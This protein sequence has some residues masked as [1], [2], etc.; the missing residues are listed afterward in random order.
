[1]SAREKEA[2]ET[3][4]EVA[5]ESPTGLDR[6]VVV[7]VDRDAREVIV[8]VGDSKARLD[9]VAMAELCKQTNRAFVEVA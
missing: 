8:S 3:V 1:M 6:S 2:P 9:A 4:G 7:E 5:A